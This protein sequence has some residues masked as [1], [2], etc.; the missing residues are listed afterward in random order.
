M[1]SLGLLAP[2]L[3][4]ATTLNWYSSPGTRAGTVNFVSVTASWLTLV[5]RGLNLSF[6]S[7]KYPVMELPPSS[8]GGDQ[9]KVA[10]SAVTLEI[11]GSFGA[12]GWPEKK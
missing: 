5:Q 2:A 8:L 11:W 4:C 9:V 1:G 7:M 6:F 3:F 12:A 10:E